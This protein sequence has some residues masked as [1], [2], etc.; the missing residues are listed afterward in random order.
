MTIDDILKLPWPG[1]SAAAASAFDRAALEVFRRQAVDCAPYREYLELVG[2]DPATVTRVDEIPFLP[3]ELFKTHR[4][5]CGDGEPEAVFTSSATGGEGPSRHYIARLADYER[6]YMRGFELF[7]GPASRWSIYALLPSYLEREGSSLVRMADGLISQGRAAG[8]SGG[9]YLYDHGKL[10]AD[11]AVD[12]GPKILLGVS[13]ALLD[14]AEEMAGR[15]SRGEK[16]P[17]GVVVMETGGMKGRREEITKARMHAILQEAFGVNGGTGTGGGMGQGAGTSTDTG[18]G[19][20]TGTGTGRDMGQGTGMGTGGGIHSEYGMAELM[21]Q[22]YSSGGGIFRTPPWMRVCVRDLTDPFDVRWAGNEREESGERRAGSKEPAENGKH[23][24]GDTR[25]T[26]SQG[27][28]WDTESAADSLHLRGGINVIDLANLH[29]C[30]FI[31]TQDVGRLAADGS[32]A[33]DGRV[34][35]SDIRGCNLLVQ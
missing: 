26:E 30:A 20:G 33:I 18:Q 19:T 21:S 3:I 32:F 22:A 12:P 5:Y 16:L 14:L 34:A 31:Q 10:L 24:Q 15:G 2:I 6:V 4:I 9:F 27:D 1:D 11:M 7:Y 23:S 28:K 25:G 29:S 17:P 35:R 8:R 13:Y